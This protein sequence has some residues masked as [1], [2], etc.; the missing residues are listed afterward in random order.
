MT[1]QRKSNDQGS[2]Y[3]WKFEKVSDVLAEGSMQMYRDAKTF[4]EGIQAENK[5]DYSKMDGEAN[6]STDSSGAGDAGKASDD[7]VPF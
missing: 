6:P 5:A 2:W 3:I 7:E 1:T 4:V